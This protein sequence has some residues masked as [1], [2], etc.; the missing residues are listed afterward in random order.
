MSITRLARLGEARDELVLVAEVGVE[1]HAEDG[2]PE[3]HEVVAAPLGGDVVGL[4][5]E[6]L[7]E[8][9]GRVVLLH[10]DVYWRRKGG[11]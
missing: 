5:A 2:L 11:S 1:H 4:L 8:L 6:Q 3:E 9:G 7:E 10:R